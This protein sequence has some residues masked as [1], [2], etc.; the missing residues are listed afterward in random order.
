MS[1]TNGQ[2]VVENPSSIPG[3][4]NSWPEFTYLPAELR[5]TRSLPHGTPDYQAPYR[6]TYESKIG[7]YHDYTQNMIMMMITLKE[8]EGLQAQ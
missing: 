6:K 2:I 1:S 3:W 8:K 5:M 7:F 4:N